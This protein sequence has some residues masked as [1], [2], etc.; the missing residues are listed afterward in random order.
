MSNGEE[1]PFRHSL[2]QQ[3]PKL[4]TNSSML[5]NYP[6]GYLSPSLRSRQA[7][8]LATTNNNSD[9]P[10]ISSISHLSLN[11]TSCYSVRLQHVPYD[12]TPREVYTIFSLASDFLG[13]DLVYENNNVV[14]TARFLSMSEA[15]NV[16]RILDG[17][18]IFG[19]NYRPVRVQIDEEEP[20]TTSGNS[21]AT[22]N[23]SSAS[24]PGANG[25]GASSAANGL[26]SP[27]IQLSGNLGMNTPYQSPITLPKRHLSS[28]TQ[29]RSRFLFNKEFNGSINE[30]I[31]SPIDLP[32][33]TPTTA[34]K[35]LLLMETQ[36]DARE[37]EQLVRDPWQE[38]GN[39]NNSSLTT[40][41]GSGQTSQPVTPIGFEW[42]ENQAR[43]TSSSFF[44]R[45]KQ[46]S[47]PN[48]V[49]SL[50][51]NTASTNANNGNVDLSLLARVP[52]P[53]N[54]ADQNPPCNTLY[55]GNLPPDATESELRALFSPQKGFRRLSFKTKAPNNGN[56]NS[57]S[58]G[59]MCFV[60]F[61][62]VGYATRALAELYGRALPR[63]GGV[64]NKGGIRLSFSKNPLGVR[65]PG[66]RRGSSNYNGYNS[67]NQPPGSQNSQTSQTQGQNQSQASGTRQ[68]SQSQ[69]SQTQNAQSQTTQT[70]TPQTQTQGSQSQSNT[71]TN[72]A[73][74]INQ[75]LQPQSLRSLQTF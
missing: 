24:V 58:H 18:S 74:G 35:S 27:G 13:A 29:Q 66:Q 12:L 30:N 75:Q 41:T 25:V 44:N 65:G 36:A 14:V 23:G 31:S 69:S 51:Q 6:A 38:G 33:V 59:P 52:L 60:E 10:L 55:V 9:S 2:L 62:D 42:A 28:T 21:G 26:V 3:L 61:D 8:G 11:K 17:K 5:N 46:S 40:I 48:T 15:S 19:P 47:P 34:G 72:S 39:G 1:V 67:F 20:G 71:Q 7:S 37:Y 49:M 43:R 56:S 68:S 63:P 16:V 73:Q 22:A 64:S 45:T 53:S 57:H 32:P 4:N 50:N 70:P 54:P